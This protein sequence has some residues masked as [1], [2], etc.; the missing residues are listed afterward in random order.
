M[1]APGPDEELMLRYRA[2]DA[3]AFEALYGRHKGGLFRFLRRQC[4][5]ASAAEELF[6]EAWIR[7]IDAR[8]RYE[9]RA[10]FSTWL[11]TIAHNLLMDHYRR[12]GRRGVEESL[13]DDDPPAEPIANPDDGPERVF[14]R[15]RRAERILAALDAIPDVQRE[16]FLLQQEAGLSVEAIA[17]ATG[18][19]F[20]TAK[21][22]LRYAL[23][24]LR[25]CLEDLR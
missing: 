20:E 10:K 14:D 4:A 18:V 3:A 1:N 25:T 6:Q 15:K 24:K 22:R 9:A 11:Y 7:V 17:S 8:E 12:Q 21:S 23:A 2:G 13:D 19:P 5:C 16:A